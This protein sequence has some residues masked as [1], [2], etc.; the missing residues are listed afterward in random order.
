MSKPAWQYGAYRRLA[1][2]A[3]L[4]AAP[5]L[6]DVYSSRHRLQAK[7]AS[8]K[9]AH[10]VPGPGPVSVLPASA[11][12]AGAILPPAKGLAAGSGGQ[13]GQAQA[14]KLEGMPVK[15][16]PVKGRVPIPPQDF[17]V[18]GNPEQRWQLYSYP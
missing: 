15:A 18:N 7:P 8:K 10:P 9:V 17:Y 5:A 11:L 12:P 2:A 14:N 6:A 16:M 4:L 3:L 1:L 13:G